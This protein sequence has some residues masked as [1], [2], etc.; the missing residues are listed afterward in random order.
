VAGAG[1]LRALFGTT[2]PLVLPSLLSG[3]VMVFLTSASAFGVPYILGVSA[4]PPTLVLTTR[5]YGYV[6]LG[7]DDAMARAMV[8]SAALLTLTRHCG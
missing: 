3:A 1:P 4:T 5:I 7:G 2:L 8:L 6:L